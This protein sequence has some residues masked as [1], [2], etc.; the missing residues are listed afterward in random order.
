M[1]VGWLVGVVVGSGGEIVAGVVVGRRC[2]WRR[3]VMLVT[4]C[5]VWYQDGTITPCSSHHILVAY[6]SANEI[7]RCEQAVF[8]ETR[9]S[10]MNDSFL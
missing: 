2:G 9:V 8:L 4:G 10:Y 3:R 1:D 5:H 7:I 6:E